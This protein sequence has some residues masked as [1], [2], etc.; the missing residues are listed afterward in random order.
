M[1]ERAQIDKATSATWK[2]NYKEKNPCKIILP[3]LLS[4][5]IGW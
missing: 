1:G 2:P 4:I 5:L 3:L